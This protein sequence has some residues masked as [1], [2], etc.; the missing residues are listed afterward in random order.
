MLWELDP[1]RR[2][3]PAL[4][5]PPQSVWPAS[6]VGQLCTQGDGVD[7]ARPHRV[8]FSLQRVETEWRKASN[9]LTALHSIL[10]GDP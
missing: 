7:V 5:R 2:T 10:S 1:G 8:P 6:P 9:S 4:P 3:K